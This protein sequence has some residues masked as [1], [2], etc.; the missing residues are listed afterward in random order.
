MLDL[1]VEQICK[2]IDALFIHIYADDE[3]LKCMNTL[4]YSV[5]YKLIIMILVLSFSKRVEK[6]R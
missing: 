5:L 6:L 4:N 1:V 3:Q 2:S